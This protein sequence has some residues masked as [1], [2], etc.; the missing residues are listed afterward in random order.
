MLFGVESQ[1]HVR[2]FSGV[3]WGYTVLLVLNVISEGICTGFRLFP[4][5]FQIG[6]AI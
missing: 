4:L 5:D 2:F 3:V 1:S 6:C